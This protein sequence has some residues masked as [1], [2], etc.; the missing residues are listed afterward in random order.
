MTYSR[1]RAATMATVALVAAG[2]AVAP[3]AAGAAPGNPGAPRYSAGAASVGD[4]YFPDEGNGGY[5]VQHYDLNFSYDPATRFM[6]A[7]ATIT[8][9]ATQDLDQFNLDFRGPE[10]SSLTVNGHAHAFTRDGQELIVT[11]RPKLKAGQTFHRG[12]EVR[13]RT[14][15][16]HRPGRV[17]RGLGADRRW[18][19]RRR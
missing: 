14:G 15:R 4:P 12:G 19:L 8:A 6:D 18:R 13:R 5:D 17:D 11:P 10:I 1:L 7:T 3:E 16:D 9:I 2:S